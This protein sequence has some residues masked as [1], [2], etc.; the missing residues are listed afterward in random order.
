MHARTRTHPDART[1][2]GV[3]QRKQAPH[4]EPTEEMCEFMRVNRDMK[5][6]ELL[7][8]FHAEF[9]PVRAAADGR[10][11]RRPSGPGGGRAGSPAGGRGAPVQAGVTITSRQLRYARPKCDP[12][13]LLAKQSP[14]FEPTEEQCE[15]MRVN[16]D[17]K[18]K[19]LLAAFHAEFGP[20]RAAADG[21]GRRRPSG[22]GGG[23]AGS[24]AG[25]RGAP[26]QAGVTIT[27]GQLRYARPKCDP[28][29]T[30]TD[31]IDST[32]TRMFKAG[33]RPEDVAAA[34][35]AIAPGMS[36]RRVHWRWHHV[37][38]QLSWK[39]KPLQIDPRAAPTRWTPE[40]DR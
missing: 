7:A 23:R 9:G 5:L 18:L 19:E 20:V 37:L 13:H 32:I 22:P 8:A 27:N 31:V 3:V 26:V 35:A 39:H 34:L 28:E 17:M 16:R 29:P 10:G 4:F 15:F 11:R 2:I 25:G 33:K 21:R 40:E 14:N 24:P 38:K 30:Y 6:K 1:D 12:E 36:A